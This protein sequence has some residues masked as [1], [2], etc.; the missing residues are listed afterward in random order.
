MADSREVSV[1]R[2]ELLAGKRL[3]RRRKYAVIDGEVCLAAS[4][5]DTCTGCYESS[6]GYPAGDYLRDKN[7][8]VLGAGCSECGYTGKR[9][10]TFWHPIDDKEPHDD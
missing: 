7:G 5:V 4:Y 2:A 1:F 8:V 9:T 6:D 10:H 3:D